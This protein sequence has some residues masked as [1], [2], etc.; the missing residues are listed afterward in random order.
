MASPGLVRIPGWQTQ[1]K[2]LQEWSCLRS[3]SAGRRD[4]RNLDEVP[5]KQLH[6]ED[7]MLVAQSTNVTRL[8]DLVKALAADLTMD[9]LNQFVGYGALLSNIQENSPALLFRVVT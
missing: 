6:L 4:G 7:P 8:R 1:P 9:A 3:L 2:Q 5:Q